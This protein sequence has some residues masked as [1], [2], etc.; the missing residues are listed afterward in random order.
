MKVDAEWSGFEK[1]EI[2]KDLK[3]LGGSSVGMLKIFFM[4]VDLGVERKSVS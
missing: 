3:V 2:R 1:T 4:R